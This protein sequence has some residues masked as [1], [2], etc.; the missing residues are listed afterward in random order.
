MRSDL[1][2]LSKEPLGG[3]WDTLVEDSSNSSRLERK[4]RVQGSGCGRREGVQIYLRKNWHHLV[5]DGKLL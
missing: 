2:F 1:F 5:T 4:S 3:S